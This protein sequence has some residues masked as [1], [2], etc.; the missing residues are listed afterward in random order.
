[1]VMKAILMKMEI[2]KCRLKKK[3]L[4]KK[5]LKNILNKLSTTLKENK[6]NR[7]ENVFLQSGTNLKCRKNE[8]INNFF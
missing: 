8:H 3:F 1:M 7:E 2:T 4:E 6:E 5:E